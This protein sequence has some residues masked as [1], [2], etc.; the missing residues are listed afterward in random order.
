MWG[1]TVLSAIAGMLPRFRETPVPQGSAPSV[2]DDARRDTPALQTCLKTLS[3]FQARR[4][5]YLGDLVLSNGET[6]IGDDVAM[7][8]V[9]VGGSWWHGKSAVVHR[10]EP[11]E[12]EEWVLVIDWVAVQE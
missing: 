10:V 4:W 2:S 11:V 6:Y 1:L 9:S 3:M 12:G 5:I 7:G 8:G